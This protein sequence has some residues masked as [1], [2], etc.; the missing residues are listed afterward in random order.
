MFKE[1]RQKLHTKATIS[2]VHLV[3]VLLKMHPKY[4]TEDGKFQLAVGFLNTLDLHSIVKI[5][6]KN[7]TNSAKET[8][9]VMRDKL[10][11]K[12]LH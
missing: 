10:K 9:K 11:Q 7:K 3:G 6:L 2:L 12:F 4:K 5:L 8:H 1:L